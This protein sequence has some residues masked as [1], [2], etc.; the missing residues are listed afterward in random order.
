MTSPTYSTAHPWCGEDA[1]AC[2]AASHKM[3]VVEEGGS[4]VALPAAEAH[5]SVLPLPAGEASQ[6]S[7]QTSP[8]P[9]VEVC[10]RGSPTLLAEKRPLV[11]LKSRFCTSTASFRLNQ[12]NVDLSLLA[13]H[14]PGGNCVYNMRQGSGKIDRLDVARLLIPV[15][16]SRA[17]GGLRRQVNVQIFKNG[18]MCI[19]GAKSYSEVVS[20]MRRAVDKIR[21]SNGTD[22][23]GV[24]RCA[25][26]SPA[27]LAVGELVGCDENGVRWTSLKFDFDLG[28]SVKLDE[29]T[30]VMG[31]FFT[32][33]YDPSLTTFRGVV[34]KATPTATV[35]IFA[36]GNGFVSVSKDINKSTATQPDASATRGML[37]AE[38]QEAYDKVCEILWLNL[39]S[40]VNLSA[41]V[42][43]RKNV[44]RG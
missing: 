37:D 12:G 21:K 7:R 1:E 11:D 40:L 10:G 41:R 14:V 8:V 20:I 25:V 42:A 38:L 19:V 31:K 24:M 4:V 35:C 23:H 27:D 17:E 44:S 6:A 36:T 3:S 32:V 30:S 34:I 29:L 39:K 9:A 26:D 43:K 13:R 18:H 15:A 33:M 22:R 16:R 2:A 5:V 28:F